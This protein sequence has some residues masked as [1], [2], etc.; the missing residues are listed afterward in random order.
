MDQTNVNQTK[1]EDAAGLP[2]RN[3]SE[4]V[5]PARGARFA[6]EV[7]SVLRDAKEPLNEAEILAVITMR[8][9]RTLTLVFEDLILQ[10]E[11]GATLQEPTEDRP[12]RLDDFGFY[13]F[14]EE[15]RAERRAAKAEIRAAGR[16]GH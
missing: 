7:V 15:E 16:T 14:T 10:G 1:C 5:D 9:E 6:D 2:Q 4:A 13:S 8:R 3:A 11:C 12:L